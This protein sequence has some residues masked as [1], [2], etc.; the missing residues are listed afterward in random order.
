MN[1]DDLATDED[2]AFAALT[3]KEEKAQWVLDHVDQT[4]VDLITTS[5]P[6]LDTTVS[7]DYV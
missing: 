5:R 2:D 4:H 1:G 3:A 7:G 6:P